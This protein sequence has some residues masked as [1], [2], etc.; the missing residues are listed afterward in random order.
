MLSKYFLQNDWKKLNKPVDMMQNCRGKAAEIVH[1]SRDVN[2][3]SQPNRLSLISR[4]VCLSSMRS[5]IFSIS[6]DL[7]RT[8]VLAHLQDRKKK[9]SLNEKTYNNY[10]F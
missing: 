9:K 6:L 2:T 4:S 8:G 7:S 10:H 5:A 3:L 1:E